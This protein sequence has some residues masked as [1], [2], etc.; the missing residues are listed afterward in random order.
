MFA[1]IEERARKLIGKDVGRTL[2]VF[3]T[4][5]QA[6]DLGIAALRSSFELKLHFFLLMSSAMT[7]GEYCQ[8]WNFLAAGYIVSYDPQCCWV[9]D[10]SQMDWAASLPL[11]HS[12]DSF[13]A[14]LV[15]MQ[16]RWLGTI[17]VWGPH[18]Q[19]YMQGWYIVVVP[20]GP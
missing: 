18:L 16:K 13:C 4:A 8:G 19:S 14:F 3:L 20:R 6:A 17:Y 5:A 12:A 1:G 15:S 10:A 9:K 11:V 7:T 2:D